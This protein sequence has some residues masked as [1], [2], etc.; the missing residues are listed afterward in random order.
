MRSASIRL[1]LGLALALVAILSSTAAGSV[2]PAAGTAPSRGGVYRVGVEESFGFSDGFDPTGEY[3]PLAWAIES[4]LMIRTLVG[5]DHVAGPAGE[6]L[7]ADLATA[8]PAPTDG[9][10]TYTFHLRPGVRFGPPVSRAVTSTDVLY[11]LERIAHPKNGAQYAFYYSPIAGFDAY[12]AG[13]AKSISGIATPDARTIVFHL[14]KPTGDFLYRLSL[15]ATGPVPVEVAGCFEGR[16]GEYGRD[17]VS[18]GPYMV[19]GADAVDASSCATLEPM[20]GFDPLSSLTLVR[21][22]DYDPKTDSPAARESLPDEF[23]FTVD[24]SAPDIV[25]R[26]AAGDLDD[27]FAVGLPPAAIERY[28]TSPAGNASFHVDPVDRTRYLSMNLTQPPFD[29]VHV[30]RAMNWIVDKAELRHAWGGPTAGLIAHHILPDSMFADELAGYDPYRTPGGH[31][32]LAKA[33]QAMRGSKYDTAHV[34]TCS[35]AACHGVLLLADARPTFEKLLPIVEA[36]ARRIGITF[37][38]ESV[39]GAAPLLATTSRNVPFAISTAWVKDYPDPVTFFSPLFDGRLIVPRGNADLSLVGLGPARAKKLGVTGNTAAVPTVDRDLDRCA[40]LAGRARLSCYEQLD[41]T[42]MTTV[43]PWI[44]Y[45]QANVVHITGPRVT[46]WQ[47]DQFS[48]T[49]AFAHVA[50]A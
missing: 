39:G 9:G 21:N 13:R 20:S 5:Y 24:A 35:A 50:V 6:R 34:G 1:R 36:D 30:R 40:A 18:T 15:P 47:F 25:D 7:V 44:P 16:P 31:G 11:A 8:V 49:T 2:A 48:A 38:V 45:L 17:V 19:E 3:V 28:A 27:E 4:N 23:E 46:R 33:R 41:R 22:P 29:D 14:T 37:H 26:V 43:V 42:L 10:R 12:A 32:S